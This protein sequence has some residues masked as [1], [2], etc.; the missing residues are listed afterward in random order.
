MQ[1]SSLASLIMCTIIADPDNFNSSS[2]LSI[3]ITSSP[4]PHFIHQT[5][6]RLRSSQQLDLLSLQLPLG[7]LHELHQLRHRRFLLHTNRFLLTRQSQSHA[8][9]R[10]PH[11]TLPLSIAP[12][13]RRNVHELRL[14]RGLSALLARTFPRGRA[15]RRRLAESRLAGRPHQRPG[16][17]SRAFRRLGGALNVGANG[18]RAAEGG[19]GVDGERQHGRQI[20]DRV[21]REEVRD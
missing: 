15:R 4:Q 21:L 14:F 20:L 11:C 17:R 7:V 19:F 2:V 5:L 3:Y 8:A 16:G 10:R 13:R 12:T 18:R 6:R 9:R 1:T